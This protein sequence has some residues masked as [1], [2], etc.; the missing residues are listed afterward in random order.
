MSCLTAALL[1]SR[2]PR[3]CALGTQDAADLSRQASGDTD[4]SR[5]LKLL[6]RRLQLRRLYRKVLLAQV[7]LD[8]ERCVPL[9]RCHALPRRSPPCAQATPW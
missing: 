8:A 4:I 1:P 6:E 9:R 5:R 3:G 7:L 2:G